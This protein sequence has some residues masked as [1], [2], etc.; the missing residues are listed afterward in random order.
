MIG[1]RDS[2]TNVFKSFTKEV[3]GAGTILNGLTPEEAVDGN[4]ERAGRKIH[5][6]ILK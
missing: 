3:K 1:L 4:R 6:L 2:P 5:Y